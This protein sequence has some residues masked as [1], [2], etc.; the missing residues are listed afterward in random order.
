MDYDIQFYILKGL[1]ENVSF[2]RNVSLNLEPIYFDEDKAPVVKF[3]KNYFA[4]YE[5][6]P[7]YSVILNVISGSKGISDDMKRDVEGVLNKVKHLEFN[8]DAEGK[9]LF[10]KTKLFANNKSFFI[11]LKQGAE[12]MSVDESK[13]DFGKVQRNMEKALSM[14]W[15]DDYGIEY[16]DADEIDGIY[17][18]LGDNTIRI[19]LGIQAIDDAINGGIPGKTKFCAVFLGQAG[20]GK[21]L[22]LGNVALNAVVAGKNVLYITFE[23]D[24]KELRKRIDAAFTGHSV[25]DILQ[26]RQQVKDK[27]IEAKKNGGVGRLIIKEFPPASVSAIDIEAFLHSMKIKRQFTPDVIVLDYLGIMTSISKDAKNSYEKGKAICEEI[28]ALS[29]RFKCPILSAVQS[30]RAGFGQANVEM[31]N[32]ADSMG[33]AHTADLII[34]LAQPEELKENNQIKFEIIKSRISKTGSKGIVDVDYDR[35]KITS[36]SDKAASTVNEAISNGIKEIEKEKNNKIKPKTN[37]I[38]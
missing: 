15:D 17:D 34:S 38:T 14:T 5:K 13:Q 3:V 4:K 35:L 30:N 33:I 26:L 22:I 25:R 32:I 27:V 16:F 12:E 19:P 2:F 23:I 11:A 29:D 10:D 31:D 6:I 8:S 18:V 36:Q 7:E 21:T 1:L 24:Q 28:R 37:N 9:W 20:L